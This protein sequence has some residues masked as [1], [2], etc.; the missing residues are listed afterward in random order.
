[1][2]RPT[3]KTILQTL[4]SGVIMAV[5]LFSNQEASATNSV[6]LGNLVTGS[7]LTNTPNIITVDLSNQCLALVKANNTSECP[8]YKTIFPHD[9]SNQMLS[10]KFV[11]TN[12]FFHRLQTK[13]VNHWGMYS[14]NKW[15]IMIDPDYNAIVHSKEITIVPSL[16]YINKDQSVGSNHTVTVYDK[17]F[18]MPDCSS[19]TIVYSEFLLS[20]TIHYLES[21]CKTTGYNEK[22]VKQTPHGTP[23]I[24]TSTFSSLKLQNQL[25]TIFNGKSQLH[26]E[27]MPSTGGLGPGNC[28][29]KTKCDFTTSTK[30]W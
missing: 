22:I 24:M 3:R 26:N 28:I 23:N 12:G 16:T 27:N 9:N 19:A 30:K 8:T 14:T 25:K 11:T 4:V 5:L 29:G 7:V 17:R 2:D 13:T 1:M 20:D 15:I 18:V 10:G 21:G 6:N